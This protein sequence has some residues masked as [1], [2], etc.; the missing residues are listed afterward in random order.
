MTEMLVRTYRQA[1]H[2]RLGKHPG[3]GPRTERRQGL[4]IERDVAV[5]MRGGLKLFA[6]VFRPAGA[7]AVP[8]IV[9]S[10]PFGKHPHIDLKTTFAGSDI[11][12][13]KLSP[14]TTF[15]VFDPIRWAKEGFAICVVDGPGNWYSEGTA[16]FFSGDEA[17]AGYDTVEWFAGRPWCNGRVGWGGV[18]YYG[19]TAWSVA[20]LQ[21][22]NLAAILPWCAASDIYRECVFTGGIP[23]GPL[24]HNW[25]LITGFGLGEVEDMEA[26]WREHPMFDEY[27]RSRVAD[28]SK[29]VVPTYAA[30]EWSNNL[31]LRGT[32]EAW[33]HLGSTHKY[34]DVSGGKEWAEF[35]SEWAFERQRAFFG[36]FLKGE[37][38]GVT[39][40]APVRIAMRRNDQSWSFRE[41]KA[42]PLER[43]RYSKLF[44]DAVHGTLVETPP[45]EAA[46]THYLSTDESQR[47]IFDF[48]FDKH[49]EI[50]GHCKLRLWIATDLAND[51]DLFVGIEKLDRDG[52]EV[53]F[54]YSQMYNDGP[55]AFG[56][57]RAS[58]REL[59]QARSTPEQPH[60]TH[61]RCRWLVHGIPVPVDIEIWPTSIVFEP[62]E[63][64]RLVVQG[65]EIHKVP[66]AGFALRHWPLHNDGHHIIHSGGAFDSHLLLPIVP[67]GR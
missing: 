48:R 30:T 13:E 47:A 67:E 3:F 26:G 36:E 34:L 12:F 28:W 39:N 54:I 8:A 52:R 59:D 61:E 57:L 50:T 21:P 14:E 46:E 2:P 37:R 19:M 32:L 16:R 17:Q 20:A 43:V 65:S 11:P 64:L 5:P 41:E 18:S 55:A 56:W 44:L 49:T 62:D 31:H 58:H 1:I 27:W 23:L 7:D 60:H 66:G 38:N 35:Y 29:V 4:I 10:A 15:E 42:W 45:A 51:A 25:M 40:W 63:T 22:P 53:P 33:K 9:C 6:D 24:T